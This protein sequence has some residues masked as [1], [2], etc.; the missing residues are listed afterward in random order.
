MLRHE[1]APRLLIGSLVVMA[2]ACQGELETT[3]DV[4]PGRYPNRLDAG[5]E[6]V[7][8]VV[9]RPLDAFTTPRA[10]RAIARAATSQGR[11]DLDEPGLDEPSPEPAAEVTGQV[12][13]R[14]VDADGQ[15]DAVARFDVAELRAAGLLSP[16]SHRI[17]VRIEGE[18]TTWVGNDRLFDTDAPLIVLPEPSG[19]FAVGSAALLVNDA[20]RP[21]S[22][23][24]GRALLVRLWYP[25]AASDVQPAPYFL[26]ERQA[27]RNLRAS[28]LPLP[29]DLFERTH[30]FAR[31]Y[32]PAADAERRPVLI[33]ST[34]WGAPVETYGALAEDFASQGYL[35][36]GINHPNGAG[37]V[38]YP[39]GSEASLDPTH[40]APD[41]ANH[42]DWALDIEHVAT[43]LTDAS[44]DA[45]ARAS[46]DERARPNVRAALAQLDPSRI[47]ALGHSFGGSAAV[48]ADADSAAIGAS[49]DLD[50]ALVGDAAQLSGRT[51]TLVLLSPEHSEY[52]G[53]IDAFLG[54][55]GA[56]CRALTIA[57]TL[58]SNYGDTG[59]L[60]S[61]V[62]TEYP[63][64]T[65]EGYQLGP[66]APLRAHTII[67][68]YLREFFRAALDGAPAPLLDGPSP[69]FPEVMFR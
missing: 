29:A 69:E 1:T 5:D 45:A 43:W 52:D 37:A 41:E 35:V 67:T 33:L 21:G 11:P 22:D 27:E 58:H 65:R 9:F 4:L 44:S 13:L 61:R 62:L 55:P 63:D 17:E 56:D 24:E 48:R 7:S 49:A 6:V 18:N 50:G 39:D 68:T 42:L 38:V 20:S 15:R 46:I 60:Y 59:W 64:L 40:V 51:R 34:G 32:V 25:A 28:P 47:A 3:L 53:S 8:A 31:E 2:S 23:S 10:P 12:E 36:F 26:D 54:A 30:G 19:P 16:S 57:E 14:D 66:I